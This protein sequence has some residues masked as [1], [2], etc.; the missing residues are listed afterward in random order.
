MP[1]HRLHIL[2]GCSPRLDVVPD[3][4]C[5]AHNKS[6][7]PKPRKAATK[8][9]NPAKRSKTVRRIRTNI[10]LLALHS[11]LGVKLLV[12]RL[13]Y[14]DKYSAIVEK[15]KVAEQQVNIAELPPLP[16][17]SCGTDNKTPKKEFLFACKQALKKKVR[18]FATIFQSFFWE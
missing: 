16:S 17:L 9:L 7:K 10:Y 4:Q 18:T 12:I 3:R 8:D 5:A 11:H 6:T 13:N 14:I 2:G 15:I 1:P